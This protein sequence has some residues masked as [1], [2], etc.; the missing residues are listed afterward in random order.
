MNTT[1]PTALS[2]ALRNRRNLLA[3][4]LVDRQYALQPELAARYGD[5]GRQRCLED[6]SIHLAMLAQ[7][8]AV[9]RAELFVDYIAWARVMLERR[10]IPAD[11]LARHLAIM[12]DV[13]REELGS[14]FAEPAVLLVDSSIRAMPSMPRDVPSFLDEGAP[15]AALAREYLDLTLSGQ[16]RLASERVVAAVQGGVSPASIY[17]DVFQRCQRETGRLWQTNQISVAQEHHVSA[18]TQMTMSQL[19]PLILGDSRA[20]AG[21]LVA[22]CAAGDL[23]EIGLRMVA[24]LLEQ[25][26]WDVIYLGAN[27]PAPAVRQML[28]DRQARLLVISASL[29]L[30]LSAVQQLIDLVRAD[31]ACDHVKILVGGYPFNL[32]PGLWKQMG[33]DGHGVDAPEAVA[34]ARGVRLAAAAP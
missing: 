22:A 26:G 28:V 15:L 18:V 23:H 34:I 6:A 2:D 1:P 29:A 27:T 31:A 13:L 12:R 25:D 17:V 33:A 9:G 4:R 32:C 20:G 3:E 14:Q 16:R 19:Y 7:S 8:L 24:D 10:G 21:T 5:A 30:H 11:D